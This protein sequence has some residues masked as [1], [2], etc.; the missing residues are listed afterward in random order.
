MFRHKDHRLRRSSSRC[1]C[2]WELQLP[3][4]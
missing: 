1:S 2:V 3:A 4:L